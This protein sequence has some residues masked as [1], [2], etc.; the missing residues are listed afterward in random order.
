M[1]GGREY[2]FGVAGGSRAAGGAG[3]QYVEGRVKRLLLV[4]GATT[5]AF[6][7]AASTAA[8]AA[9]TYVVRDGDTLWGIAARHGVS[10]DAILSANRLPNPDALQLGQQLVIPHG[11]AA[12]I[13]R[14]PARS[15]GGSLAHVVQPG[16]TLWGIAS[17]YRVSVSAIVAA[18]RLANPDALQLGQR[19]RIPVK[20]SR[21]VV[22]VPKSTP[23]PSVRRAALPAAAIP[24]RGVKWGST[25]VNMAAR[26]V[27]VRYRWGG[28][29]PR[30]FDCSGFISYVLRGM[31]VSVPR[32]TYAMWTGGRPV[33]RDQLQ[34][35]DVVFFHT[36]RP[37]ASHAGI[38]IGNNQF[39]H[40][41]SG[42]GRVTV[43]SLDYRYYKPR[44]VGARRFP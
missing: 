24:S 12:Q 28:M 15:T 6:V 37:G 39:I 44:Y 9:Q 13:S 34:V 40:S 22:A 41:S 16:E 36:T 23:A 25:L 19:L 29:S 2:P 31:G 26:F 8:F 4:I 1:C 10:V 27:G 43:T 33:P 35:G 7:L 38:Y 30:G 11:G 18:N 21:A 20:G 32:T 17:K 3:R 42:F 14:A 5:I